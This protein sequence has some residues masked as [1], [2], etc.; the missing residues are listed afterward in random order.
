MELASTSK[1]LLGNSSSSIIEGSA[2]LLPALNIGDRQKN[3]TM[4]N[5]IVNSSTDYLSI[6]KGFLKVLKIKKNKIRRI[7]NKKNTSYNIS[8]LLGF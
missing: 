1:M 5:N 8:K 7:F 3:R 4:S 6:E 2:L